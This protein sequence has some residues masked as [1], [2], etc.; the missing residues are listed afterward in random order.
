[1]QCWDTYIPDML[2]DQIGG[3][4]TWPSLFK[5]QIDTSPTSFLTAPADWMNCVD[6]DNI[7]NCAFSWAK[8]TNAF[9]CSYAYSN[10]DT[11]VDLSG[12]YAQGAFPIIETQI[13]KGTL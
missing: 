7:E 5:S 11:S 4:D 2:E 9:T 10:L 6:P 1:M 3:F 13:A 8:E 12:D